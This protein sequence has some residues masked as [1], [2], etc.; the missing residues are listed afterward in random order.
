MK[1]LFRTA[2]AAEA[3]GQDSEIA[4]YDRLAGELRNKID[5]LL[6]LFADGIIAARSEIQ[7]KIGDLDRQ[8]MQAEES[9]R[10]LLYDH[11]NLIKNIFFAIDKLGAF[12][13]VRSSFQTLGLS[14]LAVSSCWMA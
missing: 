13:R 12:I 9:R 2:L 4:Y 3:G 7:G 8:A 6:D 10:A 14:G 11:E 5:R 1:G